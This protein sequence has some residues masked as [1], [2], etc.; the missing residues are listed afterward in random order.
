M[1]VYKYP[2]TPPSNYFTLDLPKGAQILTADV[3][4]GIVCLWALV[5]PEAPTQT[6]KFRWAGTGHEISEAPEN[7][8]H[9]STFFMQGELLV[10][11]IFEILG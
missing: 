11:H 10:F 3:Q 8:R 5:D 6:R 2:I 1:K 4:G 7:L 9:V